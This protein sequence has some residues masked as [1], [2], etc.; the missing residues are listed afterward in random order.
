M[1]PLLAFV[2]FYAEVEVF[3]V[4]WVV[5]ERVGG[6]EFLRAFLQLMDQDGGQ[7]FDLLDACIQAVDKS[8]WRYWFGDGFLLLWFWMLICFGWYVVEVPFTRG[9]LAV[10]SGWVF[11]VS[12]LG[13]AAVAVFLFHWVGKGWFWAMSVN[14]ILWLVDWLI[15]LTLQFANWCILIDD[16]NLS[17]FLINLTPDNSSQNYQ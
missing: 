8:G 16:F 15:I 10:F 14:Y 7:H 5:D 4:E 11:L 13:V 12:H 2:C 1:Y 17:H 9:G 6:V 3:G